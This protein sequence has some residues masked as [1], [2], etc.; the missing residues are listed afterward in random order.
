MNSRISAYETASTSRIAAIRRLVVVA[1][2]IEAR[3]QN[4]ELGAVAPVT[5][6]LALGLQA[7][8][9]CANAEAPER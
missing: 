6:D 5:L 9:E 4:R 7:L 8:F 2:G 1:G 3:A